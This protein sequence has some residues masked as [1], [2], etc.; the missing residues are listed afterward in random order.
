M[1]VF[2]LFSKRQKLLRGEFPDVYTYDDIPQPLRVQIVHILRDAIG[3]DIGRS[4]PIGKP[5]EF[6]YDTLC[7]EYPDL[8]TTVRCATTA[9][10]LDGQ[11]PDSIAGCYAFTAEHARRGNC[12]GR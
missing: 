2:D 9:S 3:T 4:S 11:H 1:K 7:R 5:Y 8:G 12:T 10:T 6:I